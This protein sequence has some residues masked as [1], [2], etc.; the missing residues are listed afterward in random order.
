M[1]K[2]I[3]LKTIAYIDFLVFTISACLIDSNSWLPFVICCISGSYLA[4][5]A[6]ANDWFGS[7]HYGE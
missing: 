2:N 4:A 7:D 6:Y 3:I 1:R 5:F